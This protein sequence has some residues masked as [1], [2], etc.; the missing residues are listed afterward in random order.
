MS[1]QPAARPGALPPRGGTGAP[2][3]PWRPARP[4]ALPP[5]G[6]F[7]PGQPLQGA[8]AR[9]R[10]TSVPR[11]LSPGV[12]VPGTPL[13]LPADEGPG[14]GPADVGGVGAVLAGDGASAP[15][16][17][18]D[19]ARPGPTTR[20]PAA[21]AGAGTASLAARRGPAAP[22]PDV[23]KG[24]PRP[25]GAGGAG[26]AGGGEDGD[27]EAL[28]GRLALLGVALLWGSYS[29]ALK[30]VFSLPVPPDASLVTLGKGAI[31]AAGLAVL[32]ALFPTLGGGG[33]GHGRGGGAGE[34]EGEARGLLWRPRGVDG[35]GPAGP[36]AW[37]RAALSTTF[38]SLP[39]A[40]LELGLW[41]FGGSA[42]QASGLALTS[43]LRAGFLIQLISIVVPVLA[44]LQGE[45]VTYR[46][47]VC[48]LLALSG[49][50]LIALEKGAG[51][52]AAGAAGSLSGDGLVLLACGFYALATVR[53]TRYAQRFDPARLA[54]ARQAAM[55]LFSLG[56]Y[57]WLRADVVLSDGILAALPGVGVISP[58][59]VAALLYIGLVPGAVAGLL[60]A[61]GQR[62]VPTAQAQV[63]YSTTSLWSALQTMA[64]IPEG[65]SLG[66]VGWAGGAV[67]AA[68]GLLNQGKRGGYEDG[69]AEEGRG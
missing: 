3:T 56:W 17:G 62:R 24:A 49:A 58:P 60:Q 59:L 10:R 61:V 20:R 6:A 12:A 57:L 35:G 67:I 41:Y 39:L 22:V 19:R 68:A 9:F 31:S 32:S 1:A 23:E 18:E 11:Q 13:P 26:G 50:V 25:R 34:A 15:L 66:A 69:E 16:L 2:P 48:C 51:A 27:R 36:R 44:F 47:W 30:L 40:G 53:L 55:L 7:F 42:C 52:G 37:A 54:S 65:E 63:I 8:G 28:V 38:A 46:T 5:R 64:L 4:G 33:H 43:S 45:R 21:L 14:H 29:P